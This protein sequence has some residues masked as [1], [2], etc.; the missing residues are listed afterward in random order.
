MERKGG[1]G[2]EGAEFSSSFYDGDGGVAEEAEAIGEEGGEGGGGCRNEWRWRYVV[3][4]EAG[5][6]EE[7]EIAQ[8][9]W[10]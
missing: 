2:G 10:R 1:E 4:S 3:S 8:G 6:G 9:E 5:E 7:E